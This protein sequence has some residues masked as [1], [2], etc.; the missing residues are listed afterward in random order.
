MKT[1]DDKFVKANKRVFRTSKVENYVYVNCQKSACSSIKSMLWTLEY[2]KGNVATLPQQN[3]NQLEGSPFTVDWQRT[4]E[5]LS[6][7]FVFTFVRNPYCRAFSSFFSTSVIAPLRGRALAQLDSGLDIKNKRVTFEQWLH[8]VKD[9]EDSERDPHYRTQTGLLHPSVI[10]Y[11]FI[12]RLESFSVDIDKVMK[13]IFSRTI[14]P[15]HVNEKGNARY[16]ELLY[17]EECIELVSEI[18]ADDFTNFKY[19]TDF[20]LAYS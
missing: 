9:I 19:S 7:G 8:F 13:S 3:G 15:L 1:V 17:T 6:N 16:A 2:D 5:V 18:Y 20:N 12:G 14:P 10:E 4:L 11:N